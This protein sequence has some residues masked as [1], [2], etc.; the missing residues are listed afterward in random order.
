MQLLQPIFIAVLLLATGAVYADN[1]S[2]IQPI[3]MTAD[4]KKVIAYFSAQIDGK[5]TTLTAPSQHGYYRVL[6]NQDKK[7]YLVQ[8]FY[9]DTNTRQT[10]PFYIQNKVDLTISAPKSNIGE[11]YIYDLSGQKNTK[12]IFDKH[13]FMQHISHYFANGQMLS[14]SDYDS[15]TYSFNNKYWYPNGSLA[16]DM[17]YNL[18]FDIIHV[19]AWHKNGQEIP[20]SQCLIDKKYDLENTQSDKCTILLQQFRNL[21][22]QAIRRDTVKK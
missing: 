20:S 14:R 12:V 18:Y 7:G 3:A 11:L 10:N 1:K 4:G 22:R 13:Y 9:Q 15:S 8:D 6:L 19:Q 17:T 2:I 16:L 5:S 21:I